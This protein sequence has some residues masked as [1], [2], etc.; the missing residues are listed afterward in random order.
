MAIAY[1][2]DRLG[3]PQFALWILAHDKRGES[4]FH[5]HLIVLKARMLQGSSFVLRGEMPSAR[6]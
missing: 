6:C 2:V 5:L 1:Q 4:Q 3:L